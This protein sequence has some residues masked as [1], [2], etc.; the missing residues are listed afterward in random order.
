MA[1]DWLQCMLK[2][3][4]TPAEEKNNVSYLSVR[5]LKSH[6]NWSKV[7][8]IYQKKTPNF[9]PVC[10]PVLLEVWKWKMKGKVMALYPVF[11]CFQVHARVKVDCKLVSS[12]KMDCEFV[13]KKIG[14]RGKREWGNG[15]TANCRSDW[16]RFQKRPPASTPNATADDCMGDCTWAG[17]ATKQRKTAVFWNSWSRP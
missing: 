16:F 15:T 12:V 5:E 7:E 13:F 2:T 1:F 3:S 6:R 11:C 10:H 4:S 9:F 14:L 17:M 8:S